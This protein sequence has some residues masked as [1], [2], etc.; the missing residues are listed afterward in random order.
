MLFLQGFQ[1]LFD[2]RD[3]EIR[4]ELKKK[5]SNG[6]KRRKGNRKRGDRIERGEKKREMT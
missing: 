6:E 1:P 2:R 3:E 4:G 5:M